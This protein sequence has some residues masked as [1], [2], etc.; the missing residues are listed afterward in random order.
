MNGAIIN[1]PN[2]ELFI[3]TIHLQEANASSE[4]ENIITTNDDLYKSIVAKKKSMIPLQKKLSAI[5][6]HYGLRRKS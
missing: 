1:L 5:K 2:P 6:M 4:I 3:D